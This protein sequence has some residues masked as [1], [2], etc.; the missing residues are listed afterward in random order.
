MNIYLEVLYAYKEILIAKRHYHIIII[1][2]QLIKNPDKT[3]LFVEELNSRD[4]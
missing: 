1:Q 2:T 4:N 3:A